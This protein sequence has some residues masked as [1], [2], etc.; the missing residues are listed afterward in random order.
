MP[1]K[2][3]AMAAKFRRQHIQKKKTYAVLTTLALAVT[4]GT[5][6][7]L[8]QPAVA[9]AGKP[10]CGIEEH[11]H[12]DECYQ[13]QLI[14]GQEESEVHTHTEECF[15]T[16]LVCTLPEHTHAAECYESAEP[17][18]PIESQPSTEPTAG[19][20]TVPAETVETT[21]AETTETT[22]AE[23]VETTPAETVE[24]T[25]TE[26]TETIPE[27]TTE[28]VPE[29]TVEETEPTEEILTADQLP[30]E[31][32]EAYTDVRTAQLVD[33]K[34]V[35]VYA[36]PDTIPGDVKLKVE[37]LDESGE[38][39]A[40]AVK[41]LQRDGIQYDY[42]KALDI[43]LCN[44]QGEEVEPLAPVY[45][46]MDAGALLPLEAS[47]ENIQIQ[48]HVELPQTLEES[49]VQ[50]TDTVEEGT[51]APA[52]AEELA[53]VAEPK[54]KLEAVLNQARGLIAKEKEAGSCIVTFPVDSFSVFTIT[55]QGW[56]DLNIKIQ[57]VDE[58]GEP[59]PVK[60]GDIQYGPAFKPDASFD[61]VFNTKEHNIKIDGYQYDGKAYYMEDGH[62]Q[63]RIYGLRRRN[64]TWYYFPK[65]GDKNTM[66]A[67]QPQ[68][69]F[70][71]PSPKNSIQ[72][73]YKKILEIPVLY[74]DDD[75]NGSNVLAEKDAPGGKNPSQVTITGKELDIGNVDLL[76]VCNAYFY[77]GRAFVGE[78]TPANE[79]FTVIRKDGVPHAVTADNREIP[80][81]TD[82]PLKLV[83]HKTQTETPD[84]ISTVST[85]AKGLTI[86]L[87]DY[88]SGDKFGPN[89]GINQGKKLQFVLDSSRPDAYNKWTGKDG[90]IYTGIVEPNLRDGY[91]VIQGESLDYL[92]DP[93]ICKGNLGS[94]VEH[95]HTN[96]DH[97][98]WRDKDGYYRYDSMTNFATIMDEAPDGSGGHSP[99]HKDGGNFI[100]YAQ[101][102]LP[103]QNATGDN[104]KFL[105]F[106]TYAQANAPTKKPAS[107]ERIKQYHFGMTMEAQFLIPPGGEVVDAEG[108]HVGLRDMIFEFNGDDDVWVFIDNKLV[109]DL[110]GIHDRYGGSI[111]F[112][113]G[114]VTTDAPPMEHSGR[115]QKNLY[116]IES[117]ANEMS[118]EALAAARAKAGFGD[119]SEH[120]FKFFY[121][122]RGRGASNCAIRFNLVPV[123]HRL[124]VGKRLPENG[125]VKSTVSPTGHMWYK[126]RAETAMPHGAGAAEGR[127]PLA[128]APFMVLKWDPNADAATGGLPVRPG[129]TDENG[130]FWL[131]A[132]ERAQF[133]DVIDLRNAGNIGGHD[134]D[135]HIYVSEILPEN[136]IV[137]NVQAWTGR[138]DKEGTYQ[139][140]TN[141]A[142]GKKRKVAPPLYDVPGKVFH[143][144]ETKVPLHP[145]GNGEIA[146]EVE[147]HCGMHN[148]FNWVDFEN[149]LGELASLNITKKALRADK[150]GNYIS[151][152]G[153]PFTIKVELWDTLRND[154]VPLSDGSP[155]WILKPYEEVPAPDAQPSYLPEGA[156]GQIAIEHDQTIHFKLLP[157][158][159][160]KVSEVLSP[161]E[162]VLYTTEYTG[163]AKLDGE[164]IW[165]E[166]VLYDNGIGSV[167]G[168]QAGSEHSVR[169]VNR[170]DVV[171]APKGTF[172]LTKQVTGTVPEGENVK[173]HFALGLNGYHPEEGSHVD[174]IPCTA[175]YHDTPGPWRGDGAIPQDGVWVQ[176]IR[177][178]EDSSGNWGTNLYLYPGETV[179][180][181]GL[182]EKVSVSVKELLQQDQAGKYDVTFQ[183]EKQEAVSGTQ[184]DGTVATI[185]RNHVVKVTCVNASKLKSTNTLKITKQV[186]RTDRPNG[187][188]TVMDQIRE[189]DFSITLKNPVGFAGGAVT[190][191]LPAELQTA[192]GPKE[193]TL[194][195][196]KSGSDYIVKLVKLKHGETLIVPGLPM[197]IDVVVQESNY[198][199]Y[200]VSMNQH[201]GDSITVHL[202]PNTGKADEVMCVNMTGVELP[203][204]G[205]HGLLP[206][207]LFAAMMMGAA[208]LLLYQRRRERGKTA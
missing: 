70:Y 30:K 176:Q 46:V 69:D 5:V 91:P 82:N 109:L 33:G 184:L 165:D 174:S 65:D 154:W 152:T 148:E 48:H 105:P 203:E 10:I 162:A 74:V 207:Y 21:P 29:E 149:D 3:K 112:R 141:Q 95:V 9:M 161:E 156:D 200:V 180:I 31:I 160:Y 193:V 142:T 102:A 63:M 50:D 97:L 11:T 155:Y 47:R 103:E 27:E 192:N 194:K 32:P 44:E 93:A 137:K 87:F 34:T 131:R 208:G 53:V 13:R 86:N 40:K 64:N 151:I 205:G 127:K 143:T 22:P 118:P 206:Y 136:S 116:G 96:L 202:T 88:N 164:V 54:V 190:V 158:T 157:G 25:P 52:V 84:R 199:G 100:V 129:I 175:T 56:K 197:N 159:K 36:L 166:V 204:T 108:S 26:T 60:P 123:S 179:V 130:Y 146:Y 99:D 191:E 1:N 104:P 67:F 16:E 98:F 59:L 167:T 73:I 134:D 7:A 182:P 41:Q 49:P 8:V 45:V 57:C 185:D 171:I 81:T 110:G 170:S 66:T 147:M 201:P 115:R 119:Y 24:T 90:G 37:L 68:P 72:L 121:L 114:E 133:T 196:E 198:K 78:P 177:F 92:F 14:C 101:P 43:S 51:E 107:S 79:V 172:S 135:V 111:N 18:A 144:A 55:S 61:I 42:V 94:T 15:K 39:F 17:E 189:F 188:P 124:V 35:S 38:A 19:Q 77:V 139:V 169:V 76:P 183:E 125:L 2:I 195:F 85:K 120:N 186:K 62:Y 153:V 117:G 75:I 138:A 168:V 4:V 113:T 128:N 89:E 181:T 23:T 150:S 173:F 163:K 122:E 140:V 178:T 28:T 187:E 58:Y 145:T 132:D 126:F 12:T 106:N 20:T 6:W 83:Y 80:L 71:G